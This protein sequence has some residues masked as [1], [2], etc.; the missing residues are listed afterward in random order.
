MRETDDRFDA[1]P[2]LTMADL[3]RLGGK[4]RLQDIGVEGIREL[5][6]KGGQTTSQRH[7]P[8]HY[9]RI[10]AMGGAAT[11]AKHPDLYRRIGKLGGNRVK[12]LVAR[13]KE[14]GEDE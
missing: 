4:Q 2:E 1:E 11:K 13:G 7:G 8:E 9:A 14:A 6:R 12:E 10:G 5:A 3:G